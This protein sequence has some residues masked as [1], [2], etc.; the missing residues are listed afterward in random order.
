MSIAWKNSAIS[1]ES[2]AP[3]EIGEP[4][5]AAEPILHLRV[6]EPVGEPVLGREA[7]RHRLAAR[8]R[9]ALTRRA[10][11]ERPVDQLPLRAGLGVE[12][13][14]RRRVWIFS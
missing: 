5:P 3:P 7:A 14:R 9:S 11:A 8:R 10:D 4:Q 1:C 12:L 13:A 6:D 2:G